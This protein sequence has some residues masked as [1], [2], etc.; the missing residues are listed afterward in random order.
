MT[1]KIIQVEAFVEDGTK[2]LESSI[3][4]F[5]VSRKIQAADLIDIKFQCDGSKRA[6]IIYE[7]DYEEK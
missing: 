4:K 3:N 2:D 7:I 5:L 6:L 1:A